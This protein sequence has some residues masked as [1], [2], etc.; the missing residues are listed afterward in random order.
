MRLRGLKY[1][2]LVAASLTAAGCSVTRHVPDGEYLLKK[3]T[4]IPD[5][6][7]PKEDRV[8]ESDVE[9]YIRQSPNNRF[10][11][12]NLY[13]GIY[14]MSN[15][16]KDGWGNRS[17]RK[18]GSA[19]VILDTTL[20]KRSNNNL[21]NYMIDRGYYDSDN[22]YEIDTAKKKAKVTYTLKQ[23]TPYR[24]NNVG[25]E[26]RD[27]HLQPVV[28]QNNAATLL[29]RGDRFDIGVLRAEETRITSHLKNNGYYFFSANNITIMADTMVGNHNT[30]LTFIIK[31]HLKGYDNQGSPIYEDNRVYRIDSIFIR[32]GYDPQAAAEDPSYLLSMDTT[33]Y[34][35]LNIMHKGKK[36]VRSRILRHTVNLQ[37]NQLYSESDVRQ[38]YSNIMRLGYYKNAS[39]VFE[40]RTDYS[41]PNLVTFIGADGKTSTVNEGYL[42]CF[43]NCIP[44]LRQSYRIELEGTTSSTFY[45][46]NTALGYQNRN[47]FRG[48]ELFDITFRGGYEFMRQKESKIKGAWE[49][50]G[51]TS[52]SFPRFITPIRFDRYNRLV[53]P[54]TKIE[55]S[56]NSQNRAKYERTIFGGYWSYGWN[57]RG[58]STF[59][60][61][62]IDINLIKSDVKPDFLAEISKN[63]FL[64]NSYES[65][66]IAGI[67]GT[68]VYNSQLRRNKPHRWVVRTNWETAG[69]LI[70]GLA[71]AFS[72]KY[73]DIEKDESY[74]RIFGIRYSQYVR[75]DASFSD[76]IIL[77]PRTHIAYRLYAGGAKSYGNLKSIP[78]DRLFY[79]GG[80]NS[81]RGWVPR[82]LGPGNSTTKNDEVTDKYPSQLGNIKLE[83]NAEL[84]YPIWKV[85]NGAI[86]FDLG[87]V[88]LA[89]K[90]NNDDPGKFRFD[91]FYK[92]L[93]FNTGLGLRFDINVAIIR[94]DW[95][96][97]L[98]DPGWPKGERWIDRFKYSNTVMNFGVGYPF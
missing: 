85:V 96:V 77:R 1:L 87:N 43:I 80:S 83:A 25:Y 60:I 50:G 17:L 28:M 90:G 40:D 57:S 84:R 55:L 72:N 2:L 8:K 63:P 10:M 22:T 86:F 12:T 91:K 44:A 62:P 66:I 27:T 69:N 18:I 4:I 49:V 13:L 23:N 75:M 81:M 42:S 41:Q 14:S 93:G 70:G 59:T 61:R 33:L 11:G 82:T 24:L 19:P 94:L 39:I 34:R 36:N 74:Y 79:G 32:P 35:G 20:V 92:Q 37:Q 88:W 48:V 58:A 21:T 73:H 97:K 16:D 51:A 5:K 68:Y 65:Q 46:I 6:E 89:G 30:D 53:N 98:H 95:G 38:A 45:G 54:R 9:R 26:F 52:L 56:I 15:P 47:L 64:K 7:T 31:Q 29:K 76:K 67:S 78:V 3:N 71:H